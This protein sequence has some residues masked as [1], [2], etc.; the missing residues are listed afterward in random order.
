MGQ[1][2]TGKPTYMKNIEV[3]DHVPLSSQGDD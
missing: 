1:T 3:S 2:L